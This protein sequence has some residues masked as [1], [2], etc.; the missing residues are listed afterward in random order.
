MCNIIANSTFRSNSI[1]NKKYNDHNVSMYSILAPVDPRFPSCCFAA[2]LSITAVAAFPY[3]QASMSAP[4]RVS[5]SIYSSVVC[6]FVLP[7]LP[8]IDPHPDLLRMVPLRYLGPFSF[9]GLLWLEP[10]PLVVFFTV[11]VIKRLLSLFPFIAMASLDLSS[12]PMAL[13]PRFLL[14]LCC[15]AHRSER[16]EGAAD[17]R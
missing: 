4:S 8:G 2:A 14:C 7:S 13:F 6:H 3:R 5:S 12:M 15:V 16:S 17:S 1:P 9:F 10:S 11:D